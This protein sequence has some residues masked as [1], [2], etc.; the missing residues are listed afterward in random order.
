MNAEAERNKSVSSLGPA[1]KAVMAYRDGDSVTITGAL[2][3]NSWTKDDGTVVSSLRLRVNGIAGRVTVLEDSP[4][5]TPA[6]APVAAGVT[7]EVPF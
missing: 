5:N 3:E 7:N 6:P 2:H 1:G 4:Q